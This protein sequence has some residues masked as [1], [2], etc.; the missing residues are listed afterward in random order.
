MGAI[1]VYVVIG[2]ADVNGRTRKSTLAATGSQRHVC[3]VRGFLV[4]AGIVPG[5]FG[6][7]Q[8]DVLAVVELDVPRAPVSALG[9]IKFVLINRGVKG[10]RATSEMKSASH[11]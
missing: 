9:P 1:G 4:A 7:P 8:I 11:V 10:I 6:D 2:V 3:V 5:I